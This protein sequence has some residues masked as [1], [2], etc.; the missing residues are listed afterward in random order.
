[1]NLMALV[2]AL[3]ATSWA[4]AW[5]PYVGDVGPG[6]KGVQCVRRDPAH[7]GGTQGYADQLGAGKCYVSI[8]PMAVGMVYRDYAFFS[9]GMLMVFNSYGAGEDTRRFT[10]AREFYFFPRVVAPDVTVDPQTP[11]VS[12]LMS[13]GDTVTFN[14]QDAQIASIGRGGVTVA[15][16]I[17]PADRGGVEFPSYNGLLLDVGFRMGE[18]PSGLPNGDAAFRSAYG[19]TCT[20]KNREIF[21]YANGDRAFKFADDELS[22]WLKTRC[23][24]LH[25]DF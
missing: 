23:P 15:Q 1:M 14:T 17:D 8:H 4:Q 10:S 13:N 12:V 16:R 3:A 24:G 21:N 25:V 18:L 22:L 7:A 11:A 20:V 2:V 19:Q 6:S 5:R 9:D